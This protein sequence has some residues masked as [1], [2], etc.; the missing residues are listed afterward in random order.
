[1]RTAYSFAALALVCAG[2]AS[3]QSLVLNP[4][5]TVESVDLKQYAGTWY[6]VAAFPQPFDKPCDAARADYSLR[7]DGQ[8]AVLSHCKKPDG[9]ETLTQGVARI[10][11]RSTNAKLE[12][13]FSGP[14]WRDYW[15]ID[16]G[17]RYDYAVVSNAKRDGLWVLSRT[18]RIDEFTYRR[19]LGRMERQ[20]FEVSRLERKGLNELASK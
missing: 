5:R 11:D 2:C 6:E 4:I 18:P 8:L 14:F 17:D 13:S 20:G 12:V 7:E 19:I 1:M 16:L 10:I 15:I 9:V 3:Q